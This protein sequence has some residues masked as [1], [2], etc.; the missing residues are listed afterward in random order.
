MSSLAVN[1]LVEPHL[2]YPRAVFGAHARCV[3]IGFGLLA[4]GCGPQPTLPDEALA[5]IK[6]GVITSLTG[7]LGTDGPGWADA[8]R[9]AAREINAAGGPLPGRPIELVVVDDE[10]NPA[11]GQT[12]AQDLIDRG[13]VAIVGAAASSSTLEVAQVTG[14]AQL[15]QISCCATSDLLTSLQENVEPHERF[16]FRTAPPDSLQSVVVAIAA[17]ELGCERL[18]ILHLDDDY[19]EPFGV[20][21]ENAYRERGG[22]VAARIPFPDEQP[23]YTAEVTDIL[24]AAPDCVA[25]VAFPGSGGTI[26][27]EWERLGGPD[28]T[29]IGTDGVRAP[30]FIDE[31]GNPAL[32]DGFYGASPVTDPATP[33]Y[34]AFHAH[35]Q[36]VF[37]GT[38]VPFSSNQ[39]DAVALLGLAIAE[40]GTTDGPAVR[41]ALHN[42]SSPPADRGFVRAGRL[43]EAL[44]E[45]RGGRNIDYQGAS[46]NVDF[47]AFGNV[48]SPYEIWRYDQPGS[49]TPCVSGMALNGG[50]RFCRYRTFTAEEIQP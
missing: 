13:V 41:D 40:A 28:V 22:T 37:G 5:P 32:V 21:I 1:S 47:D 38:P 34:N 18:A 17:D 46:G 35:Y 23:S 30:G 19:G 43:A 12:L 31:V 4:F 16:F 7:T 42:V 26:L 3:L 50:G 44:A 9:L 25:L 14:A 11:L 6:I 49:E 8:A 2:A 39:Y 33:E 10:T 20:G 48:V 15:P 27:R 36:T 45:V 24:D 29:W